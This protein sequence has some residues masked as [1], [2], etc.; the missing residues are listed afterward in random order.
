[1]LYV[2]QGDSDKV[3]EQGYLAYICMSKK[4]TICGVRD[5][6]QQVWIFQMARSTPS[7]FSPPALAAK[8]QKK[9]TI[10]A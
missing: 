2:G 10:N 6:I 1:M 5:I 3:K 9:T 4:L 8:L 7:C